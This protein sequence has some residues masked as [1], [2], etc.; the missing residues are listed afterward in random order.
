MSPTDRTRAPVDDLALDGEP[1]PVVRRAPFSDNPTVGARGQRT[2]QRIVDAALQTFGEKG[3]HQCSIDRITRL[4]GCSRV[5]FYQYFSG[6]EDLFRHLSGQVARQLSASTEALGPLTPDADG[7]AELRAWA[8]RYT[9]VYERYEPVFHAFADA[10]EVDEAVAGGSARTMERNVERIRSRLA[11][12]TLPTRQLDPVIVLLLQCVSRMHDSAGILRSMAPE[13]YPQERVA[14]AL[15]DVMHRTLFGLQPDV[16]VHPPSAK[17]PPILHFGP[18]M[19]E[20]LQ[21]DDAE[22]ATLTDAGRRTLDSLTRA[23]RDVFV[24]R[25]YHRTRVDD[26]VKEAGVSHG[27]FYRYFSSKDELAQVLAVRA[28]RNVSAAMID[29]PDALTADGGPGR[30]GALSSWLRRYNAAHATEASVIRVWVDASLQDADLRPDSAAAIDWGRRV[31]ARYLRPRGFGDLD[32]EAVV[33]VTLLSGFG[34]RNQSA[35]ATDAAAY[36]IERGVLGR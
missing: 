4:A 29:I 8:T 33:V 25:G 24:R 27:A 6:K 23:G 2:Q 31:M 18:V 13:A 28:M 30:N 14:D 17:R 35:D 3:Y 12:S 9:D 15:T 32:T 22:E 21:S 1:G 5:S 7:W 11:T 10:A 19:S 36:I 16:N 20:V 34:A 26:I